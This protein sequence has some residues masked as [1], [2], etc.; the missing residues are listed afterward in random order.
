MRVSCIMVIEKLFP[1]FYRVNQ[2]VYKRQSTTLS[3]RVSS[4]EEAIIKIKSKQYHCTTIEDAIIFTDWLINEKY[5]WFSANDIIRAVSY[6]HLTEIN[7]WVLPRLE[8]LLTHYSPTPCFLIVDFGSQGEFKAVSYT[9]LDV[10]KRQ[11]SLSLS[12]RN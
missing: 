1:V 11:L 10:Y 12:A 7:P 2:D 8:F 9:H 6:T 3:N 4:V 5:S